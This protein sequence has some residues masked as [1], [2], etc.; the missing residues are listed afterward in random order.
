VKVAS[1][2]LSALNVAVV[3]VWGT[4]MPAVSFSEVVPVF[5]E[6]E[7]AVPRLMPASR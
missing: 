4:N 7:V 5:V 6:V 2:P 1:T 3:S